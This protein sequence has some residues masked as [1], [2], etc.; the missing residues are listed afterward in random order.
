MTQLSLSRRSAFFGA[1]AL[2][3]VP[4][5]AT[6]KT[7]QTAIGA[8]WADAEALKAKIASYRGEIAA[9]AH[10]GGISG[11][12]RLGGEANVLGGMRYAR[13]MAILNAKP[14]SQADLA[15][16]ARV[17][18]DDEIHNGAKSYA[19]DQFAKA[20]LEFASNVA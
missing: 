17:I 10:N 13:L 16:M 7:K 3:L 5:V 12:M 19:A 6:A 11:W 8:L 15:I 14:E 9:A 18:L 2:S 1:A 20:T 4:V